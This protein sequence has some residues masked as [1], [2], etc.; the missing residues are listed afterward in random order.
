MTSALKISLNDIDWETYD[1]VLTD[2]DARSII[3]LLVPEV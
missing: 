1:L 3:N 2:N